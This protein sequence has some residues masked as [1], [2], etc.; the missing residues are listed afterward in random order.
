MRR[1]EKLF[2]SSYRIVVVDDEQGI[3]DSLRLVLS[4][5]GYD[6]V[7]CLNPVEAIE[8]IR[9]EHFDLL[10]LDYIMSP[11][12]GDKVV[13]LVREF[14]NELYI[15]LLTG[16]KDMAPPIETIRALDIQGYCEKSDRFD[17]LLL[18]IESGIKSIE[19]MRTIKQ[20]RDGLNKILEAVPKMYQLQPIDRIL[21]GILIEILPI[22]N[23]KN[24]FILVDNPMTE[25]NL[26]RSLYSGIGSYRSDIN[27]FLSMLAPDII[28]RIGYSRSKRIRV[29]YEDSVILPLIN[30][31]ASTLGVIYVEGSVSIEGLKLLDIYASQASSSLS[32]AFLHSL[33]NIKNEELNKTYEQLKNRYLDTIEALRLVVDAKDI[34][35]CGHSER[36]S[37]LA[38]KIGKSL[39]L[40]EADI[41]ILRVSGLFHDIGKIGTADDILSKRQKLNREEYEEI[42][43]HPSKGANILSAVSMFQEAVPIVKCHHERIDGTGYPRGLRGEEIPYLA[44]IISIADSF[45]AMCSDRS[46]RCSL[47][48]E[49]AKEQLIQGAGTQF[50]REIVFAALRVL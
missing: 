6:V 36:V 48:E 17:Q 49:Q 27:S 3:I 47:T 46:Y 18:L 1:K 43:K 12:H 38:M 19:Q 14:N 11:I 7:G 13:E 25:L 41:E 26:N 8:L 20:F 28:E 2:I 16:H 45:D 9:N 21:E 10:I 4:R 33:V 39:K 35:T 34:Y 40:N 42:K 22:V 29:H 50:D 44:K 5:S 31:Q 23:S 30:E 37:Q 15:L 32:N 24:A